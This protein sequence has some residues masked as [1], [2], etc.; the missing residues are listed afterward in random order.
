MIRKDGLIIWPAYFE[1]KNSRRAGRRVPVHLAVQKPSAD[2]LL[3]ACKRLGWPAEKVDAAYPKA[4]YFKTGYVVVNPGEK[5]S[6]HT[7]MMKVAEELRKV[8]KK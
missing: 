2:D 7:V 5:L 1:A 4:W 6:K 8:V 3:N